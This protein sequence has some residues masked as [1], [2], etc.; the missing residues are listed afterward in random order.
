METEA[1]KNQPHYETV[2]VEKRK[3][4]RFSVDLP[5]EYY[6]LGSLVKHDGKAMKASQGG[7]LLKF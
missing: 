7:L 2:N 5:V 4:Q 1:Q 6:K 3:H